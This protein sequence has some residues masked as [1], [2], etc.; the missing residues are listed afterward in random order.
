[1]ETT[2]SNRGWVR[3][4]QEVAE[5]TWRG[6]TLQPRPAAIEP[7]TMRAFSR[8]RGADLTPS[9]TGACPGP[10]S[11]RYQPCWSRRS[12]AS[13]WPCLSKLRRQGAVTADTPWKHA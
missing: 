3:L 9:M 13:F 11:S 10:P 2:Y 12:P 6:K 1:M 7:V 8:W 5:E 4:E